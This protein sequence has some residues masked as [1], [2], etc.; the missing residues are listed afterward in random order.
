MLE[1]IYIVLEGHKNFEFLK[2]T[3]FQ[4]EIVLNEKK[5]GMFVNH[6]EKIIYEKRAPM[7]CSFFRG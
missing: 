5:Q 6:F 7:W 4:P 3:W 1:R 2:L